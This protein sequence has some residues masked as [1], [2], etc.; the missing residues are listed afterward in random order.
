[1]SL[2]TFNRGPRQQGSC[3]IIVSARWQL[4]SKL[5]A[6]LALS[7]VQGVRGR[8]RPA[9]PVKGASAS[10]TTLCISWSKPGGQVNFSELVSCLLKI[11]Q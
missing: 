4:S 8:A 6:V 7:E 11:G 2:A 9:R 1:M 5:F 3:F 10:A